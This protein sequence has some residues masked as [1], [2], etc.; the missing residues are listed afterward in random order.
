MNNGVAWGTVTDNVDLIDDAHINDMR[1][2]K[3]DV[4][5]DIPLT[6]CMQWKKGTDVASAATLAPTYNG[7]YF[8]VTG[9]T[10][11]TAIN[12][13]DIGGDNVQAGTPLLLQF[14]GILKIVHDGDNIVIPGGLDIQTNAG[15]HVLLV[16]YAT[17]KWRVVKH[18][19]PRNSTL[20]N[21]LSNSGFGVWS[22]SDTNKGIGSL[23]YDNL[24]VSTFS[25]GETI[26][27]QTS[28]AVGKM[29]SLTGLTLSLGACAGRFQDNEQILGGTSGATAD[30]N[31]PDS[32]AGVDL[33]QNGDFSV[34][35]DPPPGW[36][37]VTSTLTTD[38]G[39][40][41]GNM[42]TVASSG[43]ALGKAYQ[44]I[45]TV[46]GKI[47]KLSLYFKKG[48]SD[49]GKFMIG[50]TT[51]EDSIYDSGALTDAAW[52]AKSHTFEATATTTR[53]TMQ[54]TDATITE[55]SLFD[56]VSL[57][58]I[59][60]CC[61][62]V[63][64]VAMDGWWKSATGIDI[65]RQHNDGGTLTHD[66]DYYSLKL[67]NTTSDRGVLFPN[68]TLYALEE[69]YQQFAG[70]TVTLGAWVKTSTASHLAYT[71]NDSEGSSGA[72]TYHTGDGSWQWMETTRTCGAS[73][74]YFYL[75]FLCH[76]AG[77]VNGD[78]IVYI[79]QPMLVF[80]SSIGSGNYSAPSGEIVWLDGDIQG[81]KLYSLLSQSSVAM[82]DL[83]LEAET[84]GQVP[85]G[86][87]AI[88]INCAVRDFGSPAGGTL[89]AFRANAT[90]TVG[91]KNDC[92]GLASDVYTRLTGWQ[93][94]DAS[95]DIDYQISASGANTFDIADFWYVAVQLR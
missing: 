72:T 83:N 60:P 52:T 20:Q 48:T 9:T 86:I 36:T 40:Q 94:C 34:D 55:T 26:T 10:S 23:T 93:D 71:I 74:T 89:L 46:I 17:D 33:V 63:N 62:A 11:I 73:I 28:G 37:A 77:A 29:I 69:W 19:T 88:R 53:I 5:G 44:D 45:T 30:V 8:D 66:G 68:S 59:T 24:A 90:K 75:Q 7:N 35:T 67:V 21:L 1:L 18:E 39:G 79:S 84:E 80:G 12:Q 54:T 47:Y 13:N 76:G 61:T 95:G 91:F 25:V 50:I 57:Y 65:Y 85:K 22:Q 15:D 27:G 51:D 64:T 56:E 87:K 43:A 82:T 3:F 38:A 58:E 78:T 6:G 81:V 42:M 31:M 92:S 49:S 14:D 32:A 4:D 16:S 2:Y 70:R 41:V